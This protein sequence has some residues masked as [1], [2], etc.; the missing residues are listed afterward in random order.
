MYNHMYQLQ[1]KGDFMPTVRPITDLQRNMGA[2][3]AECH[4]TGRPI[5][6]T[7]NGSAS[8]VIMDAA[9]FDEGAELSERVY[10]REMRVYRSVM[11]GLDDA[12]AGRTRTLAEA[13]AG[14]AALRGNDVG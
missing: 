13:R 12:A 8:L 2:I 3:A 4:E 6:L 5:Y 1:E 11:R 14:A 10:E 7:K 9:A